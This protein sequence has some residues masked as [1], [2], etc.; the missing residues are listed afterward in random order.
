ME[1]GLVLLLVLMAATER[2]LELK[3][4]EDVSFTFEYEE[5]LPRYADNLLPDNGLINNNYGFGYNQSQN[6]SFYFIKDIILEGSSIEN[7]DNNC[8][9]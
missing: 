4:L 7:G 6:Q 5:N 1:N 9:S 2:L 8:L 3:V